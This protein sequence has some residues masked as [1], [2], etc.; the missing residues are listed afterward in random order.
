LKI[1]LKGLVLALK[2]LGAWLATYTVTGIKG[3]YQQFL[4]SLLI[5]ALITIPSDLYL[6]NH[7]NNEEKPPEENTPE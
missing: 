7:W 6:M 2:N 3:D 4:F 1:T 5:F